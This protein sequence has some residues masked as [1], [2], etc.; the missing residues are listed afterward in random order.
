MR[1]WVWRF[2]SVVVLV[3]VIA[4]L[5][6]TYQWIQSRRDLEA[7][8]PPGRLIDVG[9]YRLHLWCS[10]QGSPAVILDSGL[11]GTSF[12]WYAVLQDVARFTTACAYDRAGMG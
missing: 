5:G 2:A 6:A 1:R 11:G 12:D 9:G 8:P 4:G 7:A 10:G 3:C